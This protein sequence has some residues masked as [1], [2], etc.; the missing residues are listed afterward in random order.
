MNQDQEKLLRAQLVDAVKGGQAH[1]DFAA[2]FGDVKH[3]EWGAKSAHAPHTLW[4]LM[5]HI[6]FATHDLVVFSTDKNYKAPDWPKDYWP[7][8]DAP[9]DEASAKQAYE[10]LKKSVDAMTTL[11]EDPKTDLFANIP[12]GDGQ[13]I[14]RE[15]LLAATHTSY[16]LGQA[17]F[18]RKE[19]KK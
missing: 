18:L 13:T 11:L 1:L 5:E 15:A 7:A 3:N 4:Q 19:F 12:W 14:L 6:R 2:V 9:A 17:M 8:S 10:G 16:H